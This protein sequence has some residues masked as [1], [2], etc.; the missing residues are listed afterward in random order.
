MKYRGD[1]KRDHSPLDVTLKTVIPDLPTKTDRLK[2][3]SQDELY[4]EIDKIDDKVKEIRTEMKRYMNELASQK[5]GYKDITDIE[6]ARKLKREKYDE[7]KILIDRSKIVNKSNKEYKD[8]I[9]KLTKKSEKLRNKMKTLFS[10]E[11][12][13]DELAFMDD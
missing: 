4:A 3:P 6:A 10:V 2:K 1:R 7:K 5:V 11:R 9:E 12:I 13:K 8:V